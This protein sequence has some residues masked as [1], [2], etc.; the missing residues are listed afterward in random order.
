MIHKPLDNVI[1]GP[2]VNWN[3]FLDAAQVLNDEHPDDYQ[4]HQK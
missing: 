4:T 1:S 2:V 3:S